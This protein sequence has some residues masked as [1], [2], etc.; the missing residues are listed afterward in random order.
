MSTLQ[1]AVRSVSNSSPIKERSN[2]FIC[3]L[4]SEFHFT[5]NYYPLNSKNKKNSFQAVSKDF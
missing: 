5:E 1:A 3:I 2:L 4:K